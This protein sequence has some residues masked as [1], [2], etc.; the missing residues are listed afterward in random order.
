[1]GTMEEW[2]FFQSEASRVVSFARSPF[3]ILQELIAY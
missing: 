2:L 1:M 3:A